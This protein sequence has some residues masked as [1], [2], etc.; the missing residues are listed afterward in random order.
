M[1]LYPLQLAKIS[2]KLWGTTRALPWAILLRPVGAE[3]KASVAAWK[4]RW[5]RSRQRP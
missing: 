4:P 3:Y 5:L 1:I 2:W